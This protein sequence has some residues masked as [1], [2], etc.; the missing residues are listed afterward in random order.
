[1]ETQLLQLTAGRGPA[2]CCWVVAQLLKAL[3]HEGRALGY[4]LTVVQREIGTESGTLKAATLKIEGKQVSS[5]T[6]SLVGSVLWIGKSK[7]RPMHKRKN[8]FVGINLIDELNT[9]DF[10]NERDVRFEFTRAR[11]PGGQHVNKVSTAVRATHIPT[12]TV[13]TAS[14]SRSQQQ[15]RKLA[16]QKLA[17]V[18]QEA[19]EIQHQQQAQDAWINHT[20]LERGNPVR[21]Y[22]GSRFTL[23]N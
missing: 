9:S 22:E 19:S 11:G 17:V 6:N 15:N 12:G 1:M 4:K 23:K 5:W 21:V 7:F 14:E 8:W 2:E 13:V 18:L 16:I 20:Q 3:A 10:L